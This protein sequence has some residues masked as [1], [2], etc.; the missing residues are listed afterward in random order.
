MNNTKWAIIVNYTAGTRRLK[1]QWKSIAWSLK[2]AGIDFAHFSTEY[3]G[4]AIEIA[5][6][7]IEDKGFRKFL[8][9]GG[10]GTLHEVVNGI[11]SSSL[12]DKSEVSLALL[13]CGTGND[14]ARYWGLYRGKTDIVSILRNPRS[15]RVDIGCLNYRVGSENRCEY[16]LNGLG[17]GLDSEV[18]YYTNKLKRLF[19]GHS[20]LYFISAVTAAFTHRSSK[21][22]IT[23]DEGDTL[24]AKIYT[25]S[26]GNGCYSGGGMKMN[27]GDPT[28]GKMFATVVPNPSLPKIL[29]GLSRLHGGH[30]YEMD[31]ARN[32]STPHLHLHTQRPQLFEAD[33]VVIDARADSKRISSAI[34]D[35]DISIIPSAL[36]MLY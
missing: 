15:Q 12:A 29:S 19:G 32:F 18:V 31:I 30:L 21:M 3:V 33:G 16:F 17:M 27:D 22:T 23:S 14:W 25:I 6:N 10:D 4:H 26:V 1:S 9:M 13:P 2:N 8:I 11:Y 24:S 20:W 5:R 28:D 36:N 34:T 7:L 35:Y